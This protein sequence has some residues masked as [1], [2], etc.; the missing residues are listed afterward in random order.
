MSD[1]TKKIQDALL[2]RDHHDATTEV[3]EA[4]KWLI[5]GTIMAGAGLGTTAAGYALHGDPMS[6]N[7]LTLSEAGIL[8]T[9]C[10]VGLAGGAQMMRRRSRD[11]VARQQY[12]LGRAQI[13]PPE[14]GMCLTSRVKDLCAYAAQLDP[15]HKQALGVAINK[16]LNVNLD[17][18][19]F[20]NAQTLT[21]V[22]VNHY[23]KENDRLGIFLQDLKQAMGTE[24]PLDTYKAPPRPHYANR[25]DTKFILPEQPQDSW[26]I[27]VAN[28]SSAE[29]QI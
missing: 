29:R 16:L 15:Q 12:E 13:T 2:I 4:K 8:V 3:T 27:E 17:Y 22:I 19:L 7:K 21:D 26:T 25:Q 5:T 9:G 20:N 1:D 14:N 10:G 11:F 23:P 6:T 18:F 24:Y 28:T